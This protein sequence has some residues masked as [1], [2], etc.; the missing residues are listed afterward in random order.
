MLLR[1]FRRRAPRK[2]RPCRNAGSEPLLV[3]PV[4]L[5]PSKAAHTSNRAFLVH[6]TQQSVP[7]NAHKRFPKLATRRAMQLHKVRNTRASKRRKRY[8]PPSEIMIVSEKFSQHVPFYLTQKQRPL[9]SKLGGPGLFIKLITQL[10]VPLFLVV[11][12]KPVHECMHLTHGGP[13][14]PLIFWVRRARARIFRSL[15]PQCFQ[16]FIMRFS[17][18]RSYPTWNQHSLCIIRGMSA[19]RRS[20]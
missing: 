10:I 19:V 7:S 11:V 6:G 17:N 20:R 4:R 18:C 9:S 2:T 8:W 16:R 13:V 12:R 14:L 1:R 15:Y 5:I 3:F